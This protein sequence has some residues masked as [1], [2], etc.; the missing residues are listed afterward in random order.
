MLRRL[1]NLAGLEATGTYQYSSGLPLDQGTD[2]LK[3]GHEAALRDARDASTNAAFDL[4]EAA[5]LHLPPGCRMFPA[6]LTY[7]GHYW[8]PLFCF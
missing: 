5:S 4:R 2:G 8:T 1:D 7:S 3:V 6:D